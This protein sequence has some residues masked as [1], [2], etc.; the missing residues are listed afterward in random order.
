[1]LETAA[2]GETEGVVGAA[3][4]GEMRL[5]RALYAIADVED[6]V[7]DVEAEKFRMVRGVLCT[8]LLSNASQDQAVHILLVAMAVNVM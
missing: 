8:G 3:G 4:R 5:W 1:M 6:C 2:A 7:R